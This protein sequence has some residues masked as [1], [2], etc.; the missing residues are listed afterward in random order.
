MLNDVLV[1]PLEGC[2]HLGVRF[3]ILRYDDVAPGGCL[4]VYRSTRH[5]VL[6]ASQAGYHT[7]LDEESF[8]I[9]A[10]DPEP[11]FGRKS[12]RLALT[13]LVS[14]RISRY[15]E[16]LETEVTCAPHTSH[17]WLKKSRSL[18]LHLNLYRHF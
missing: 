10:L 18:L 12:E 5:R 1:C 4:S 17:G 16:E 6:Y 11:K 15:A 3:S 14:T 2:C 8:M 7:C 13:E 9:Q